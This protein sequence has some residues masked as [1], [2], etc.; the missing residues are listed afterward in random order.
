MADAAPRTG[1]EPHP[2][3]P[4]ITS[5][6]SW[7]APVT[8]FRAIA[9]VAELAPKHPGMHYVIVG[10]GEHRDA[11]QQAVARHGVGDRVHFT[12]AR[13]D[14]PAILAACD[15]FV[16]PTLEDA[17]PTVLAEAGAAGLPLVA[18]RVGGVPEMVL[19]GRNGRLVPPDDV[20]A[21]VAALDQLLS[22]SQEANRMSEEAR[23]VA[24]ERFDIATQAGELAR[25]YREQMAGAA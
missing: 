10:D 17:L 14:V 19:D 22:D 13:T 20:P 9:A 23:A 7:C 15:V 1:E 16:H 21:L 25:M 12:G 8:G 11:L 18:S 5:A 6:G 2:S 3:D 24:R 4:S